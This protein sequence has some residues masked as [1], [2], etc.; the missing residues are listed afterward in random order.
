M[1]SRKLARIREVCNHSWLQINHQWAKSHQHS[2][3]GRLHPSRLADRVPRIV[4]LRHLLRSRRHTTLRRA[5]C[6]EDVWV[7]LLGREA[8]G[9]ADG[10]IVGGTGASDQLVGLLQRR[11][12]TGR[13]FAPCPLMRLFAL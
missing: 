9:A 11:L 1:P 3:R 8:V 7:A 4:D 2:K 5:G 6:A 13:R 12:W 10:G